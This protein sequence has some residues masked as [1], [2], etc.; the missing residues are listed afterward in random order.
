M[1]KFCEK[2]LDRDFKLDDNKTMMHALFHELNIISEDERKGMLTKFETYYD[3][4]ATITEKNE[5]I[6][7]IEDGKND[8]MAK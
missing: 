2:N 7:K 6:K 3:A 1:L 8:S 5:R 4:S